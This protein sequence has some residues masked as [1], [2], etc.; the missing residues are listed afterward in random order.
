MQSLF[1]IYFKLGFEHIINIGA[2]D[3][4]LFI[5]GICVVYSLKEWVKVAYLVSAFT[6]GHFISL[7][8]TLFSEQS[9][10]SSNVI[11]TAILVTILLVAYANLFIHERKLDFLMNSK[12]WFSA[13]FG[14]IHGLG[15]SNY[16]RSILLNDDLGMS[17]FAFNIGVELGQLCI[18][19]IVLAIGYLLVEKYGVKQRIWR[20]NI[21]IF[22]FIVTIG[23]LV[24]AFRNV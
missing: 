22:I 24:N 20:R 13:F 23:L 16:L 3:H 21:S 18:V 4:I 7:A 6:V 2:L 19:A 17:L 9:I 11:E 1:F 8:I 5:V 10:I 14:I 15:F 12:Y